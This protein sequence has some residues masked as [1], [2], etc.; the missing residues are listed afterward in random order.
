L[1]R[2]G[3]D[4]K[5]RDGA[6]VLIVDVPESLYPLMPGAEP[7][8]ETFP[9]GLDIRLAGMNRTSISIELISTMARSIPAPVEFFA[10]GKCP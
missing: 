9:A 2:C 8:A 7:F 5:E 10:P 1:F 3:L 4:I 6:A